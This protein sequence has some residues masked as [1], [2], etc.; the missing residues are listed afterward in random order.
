MKANNFKI[1]QC[2][3]DCHI[4][5]NPAVKEGFQGRAKNGMFI[6]VPDYL[7]EKVTDVSPNHWRIQACILKV[8]TSRLLILNT[9]FPVDPKTIR[10]D[11]T[12]LLE[13][14]DIIDKVLE[15]N[16]FSDIIWGGDVNCGFLRRT[17]FVESVDR[18]LS[19]LQLKRSWEIFQ[20]D[21]THTFSVD[22][23]T[24]TSTLDHFFWNEQLNDRVKDAGVLHLVENTSDHAVI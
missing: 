17:G 24:Y 22:E 20:A 10:F 13:I 5:V 9:Y 8:K 11:D 15:N 3:P 14:L 2:L 19:E 23:R 1:K 18:F 6:A 4:L 12:E 21:F 16:E 7:K